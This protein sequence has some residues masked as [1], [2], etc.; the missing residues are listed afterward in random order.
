MATWIR[1]VPCHGYLDKAGAKSSLPAWI[2]PVPG[3]GY[4]DKVG[5]KSW[6]HEYSWCKSIAT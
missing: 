1:L 4:L 5:A 2:R 6:L 3:H